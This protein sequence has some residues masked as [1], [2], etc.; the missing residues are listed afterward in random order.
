MI[1]LNFGFTPD[2]KQEKILRKKIKR[3]MKTIKNIVSAVT[4]LKNWDLVIVIISLL[5]T[6][7]FLVL[8]VIEC[9]VGH[10]TIEEQVNGSS[11][12]GS[13]VAYAICSLFFLVALS[14]VLNL[15]RIAS[16]VE[17]I[18]RNTKKEEEM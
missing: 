4:R 11:S 9:F 14:L 10:L 2:K 17:E 3:V 18:A 16:A 7:A 15:S 8:Y 6:L 5:I 13:V 12:F 1:D